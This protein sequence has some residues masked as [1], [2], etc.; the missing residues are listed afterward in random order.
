MNEVNWLRRPAMVTH[1]WKNPASCTGHHVLLLFLIS[2][3]KEVNVGLN[4][5]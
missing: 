2:L 3:Q 4:G 1:A 5:T